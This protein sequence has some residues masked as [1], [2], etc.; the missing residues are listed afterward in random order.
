MKCLKFI[1]EL[2]SDIIISERTATE[3]SQKTLDFIP[4]SSFMGLVAGKLYKELTKEQ[5]KIVFHDASVQFGDA[6][7]ICNGQRTIKIPL[8]W[9]V[10]KR[11]SSL[12]ELVLKEDGLNPY[13]QCRDGYIAF[14]N[15]SFTWLKTG[16]RFSLKSAYD[17][18]SRKSMDKQMFGYQ[19]LVSGSRWGF[20]VRFRNIPEETEKKIVSSLVGE[21]RLG[22][23][24][25]AEY[26]L[27]WIAQ[28][29]YTECFQLGNIADVCYIY[30]E[31]RLIFLDR[32]GQFC[33]QPEI[34]QFGIE[35]AEIDWQESR[36]RVFQYAPFNSKR[37]TRDAE[38]C[39]IEKGSVIVVRKKPGFNLDR[40]VIDH[41]VGAFRGEGFGR[42]MIN[43]VFLQA[44]EDGRIP[45]Y[46]TDA[47]EAGGKDISMIES[48]QMTDQDNV[49]YS[50]LRRESVQKERDKKVFDLVNKFINEHGKHFA[51]GR[52][53]S[54]WGKIRMFA[55]ESKTSEELIEKLFDEHTGYLNHGVCAN[56]WNE[57]NR[58]KYLEAFIKGIREDNELTLCAVINLAA[59][60]ARRKEF[61]E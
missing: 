39:G 14:F 52:F 17:L 22:K 26:G 40:S 2:K 24:R 61:A 28:G 35:N 42:V 5:S 36:I 33:L 16:K 23:S 10:P 25:S 43:P 8:S 3:G 29:E 54:Q 32:N 44:N 48:V 1:C 6:H 31:S 55:Y 7:L 9:Y 47:E 37:Q 20:D 59:E 19:S 30:A 50:F 46:Y 45:F 51:K 56:K 13:K 60:M 38:R 49:L 18:K 41:G 57:K 58:R 15:N 34:A 12:R 27:V 4:G 11:T 21:G 53:S